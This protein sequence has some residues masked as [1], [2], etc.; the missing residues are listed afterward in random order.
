MCFVFNKVRSKVGR[1]DIPR[2]LRVNRLSLRHAI[3]CGVFD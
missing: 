2:F 1:H 3:L